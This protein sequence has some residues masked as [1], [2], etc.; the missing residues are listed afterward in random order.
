[1]QAAA[2]GRADAGTEPGSQVRE[3]KE[4]VKALHAAGMDALGPGDGEA[5]L[6]QGLEEQ[7]GVAVETEEG[8]FAPVLR[9]GQ[10]LEGAEQALGL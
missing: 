5:V 4:M 9:G 10:R 1:M 2:P 3:F 6:A 7:L 8:L